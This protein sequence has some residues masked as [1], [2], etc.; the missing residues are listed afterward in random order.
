MDNPLFFFIKVSLEFMKRTRKE[1]LYIPLKFIYSIKFNLFIQILVPQKYIFD[2]C[3][4]SLIMIRQ[5]S[6][7]VLLITEFTDL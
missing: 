4:A 7:L 2:I 5:I 6:F 3:L 1:I